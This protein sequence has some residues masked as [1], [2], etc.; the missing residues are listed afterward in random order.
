M[1]LEIN[2]PQ[3]PLYSTHMCLMCYAMLIEKFGI[4]RWKGSN[5][6]VL[7]ELE[8]KVQQKKV[9]NKSAEHWYDWGP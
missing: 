7:V 2:I 4:H 3:I 8:I 1:G 9:N 5:R 6:T